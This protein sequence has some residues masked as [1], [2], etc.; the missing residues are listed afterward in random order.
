MS[1][2]AVKE[3]ERDEVLAQAPEPAGADAKVLTKLLADRYSCRAYRPDP[4][5][6]AVI[7]RILSVA[8]LS[9]SWCNAQPWQVLVT[10]GE[11]T[12]RFRNALMAHVLGRGAAVPDIDFPGK[13]EGIYKERRRE[14]AWRLYDSVG[15]T[16]GDREASNKQTF[17]NFRLFGAPHVMLI[18]SEQDLGPYGAID[19]GLFVGNVLNMCQSLGVGTIAQAALASQASFIRGYFGL[20]ETRRVV[21][22]VSFGYPDE[23][24][25]SNTFRTR[26]AAL[27]SVV[28]YGRD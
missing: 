3:L 7:N 2:D 6:E 11:G 4:V 13:Y 15:I 8:Q 26:R 9:A 28:T 20:P 14:T 1:E 17:E 25:P 5:P 21:C 27:D 18:T 10:T 16:W 19:C 23:T 22:G 12:D 24:H